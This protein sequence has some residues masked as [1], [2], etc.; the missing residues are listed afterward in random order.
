VAVLSL[1]RSLSGGK[2]THQGRGFARLTFATPKVTVR[3]N[4]DSLLMLQAHE[5]LSLWLRSKVAPAWH[6]S[7]GNN[8][9]LVDEWGGFGVYCSDP[10]VK[11]H[12]RPYEAD[13]ASWRL[14]AGA[15]LWVCV[16]PPKPYPWEQS[17]R[18]HVVWHHSRELAYPPD[19]VLAAWRQHGDIALLQSEIMLW[20]D[21]NLDF[22][23]RLGAAEFARVRQTCRRLGMRFMVYTSPYYF[24]RGTPVES[25]AINTYENFV[26]YPPGDGSG[27]NMGLFME[28][29][30]RLVR[31]HHPDGLYFD[32]QYV[33]SAPA[34]YALARQSRALLGEDGLLE[35]HSTHALGWGTC[36]LPPA[37]AY[38]DYI[39]RG[40]GERSLYA[41]P[42]YL[43]F[44]VSGYNVSNSIG[45][46]CNNDGRFD[47][48]LVDA[49]LAVNARFHTLAGFVGRPEMEEVEAYYRS[50]LAPGLQAQVDAGCDRRQAGVPARVA[51][52]RQAAQA[53][54]RQFARERR[55]LARAPQWQQ[56]ALPVTLGPLPAGKQVSAAAPGALTAA[57]GVL[58]VRAPANCFAF[59]S[60]PVTGKVQGLVVKVRQGTDGGMSWG[61]A[62]LLRFANGL[63]LRMGTRADGR[64]QADLC[65]RTLPYE[66]LAKACDQP[67]L[68]PEETEP[69]QVLA[70]GYEPGQWVWLRARWEGHWGVIERSDDG[71]RYRPVWLFEHDGRFGG[72]ATEVLVGKVPYNGRPEDFTDLGPVGE[73]EIGMAGIYR[74][75]ERR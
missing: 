46:L 67:P 43:R 54:A 38:V 15:V 23:P 26:D 12:F 51:V 66:D 56:P 57:G 61:P 1:G 39:L 71:R 55:V 25:R 17:R 47:R 45:V 13:A 22:I 63:Y 34:L 11:D 7:E 20:K 4:G 2:L 5:P 36:Y 74:Q 53:R 65:A 62:V 32:G 9:L 59:L 69:V 72:E 41:S 48:Q 44:F 31:E 21:W 30:T 75:E 49:A 27:R 3:V 19:E 70:P 14:P 40:E 18:E 42:D 6:A 37:D 52:L 28:A 73:C 35:W 68:L 50:R 8:H 64:L 33:G 24:I 60:V 58:Q 29:I 16:C 10:Q